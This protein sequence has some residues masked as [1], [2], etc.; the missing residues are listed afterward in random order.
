MKV[1]RG[2]SSESKV[3]QQMTPMI[4][5]VFQLLTFFI[6]SFKVA[7]LEGD[8]NIKMPLGAAKPGNI[9]D[10]TVPPMKLRMLA[11]ASGVLR[12]LQ[13]NGRDLGKGGG[14]FSPAKGFANTQAEILSIVGPASGS[15]PG[16]VRETAEVEL[17]CD[18]NLKYEYVIQ[19]ITAVSGHRLEDGSIAKLVE[20][21]KFSPPRAAGG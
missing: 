21:V 20:K 4:D 11:D 18:Y 2:A 1:R 3:E 14:N 5:V 15:G 10:N 8:F 7:T 13:F 17:D 9:T 16:S 12:G 19:A 6:M